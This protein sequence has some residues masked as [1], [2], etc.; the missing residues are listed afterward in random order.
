VPDTVSDTGPV[1]H[2]DEIGHLTVL[3]TAAPIVLPDLVLAELEARGLG[4]ARFQEAGVALTVSPVPSFEWREILRNIAPQ[5]QP[6]D[7]QVFALVRASRFQALALTDDL[8]LRKLLEGHGTQVA[9]SVGILVRA[10]TAKGISRAELEAAIESLFNDSSLH[11]SRAFRVY[12][13][14]LLGDLP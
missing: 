9:G 6:A 3:T 7:A 2:L 1:L 14:E 4:R 11:L 10:Y 13:K 8:A 5:I 12:L